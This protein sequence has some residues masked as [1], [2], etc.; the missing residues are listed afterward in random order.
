M[1]KHGGIAVAPVMMSAFCLYESRLTQEGAAYEIVERYPF[2]QERMFAM[3]EPAW[4]DSFPLSAERQ[5][6]KC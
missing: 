5:G 2:A 1:R 4:S 6:R 3:D